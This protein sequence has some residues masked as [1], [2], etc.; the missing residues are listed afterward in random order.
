MSDVALSIIARLRQ[1]GAIL[2]CWDGERVRFSAPAPLPAALLAEAR[3][4]RE[5]I[6]VA[7]TADAMPTGPEAATEAVA[8]WIERAAGEALDGYVATPPPPEWPEA[9][10]ERLQSLSRQITSGYLRAALRRPP[11]WSRV[12]KH[13]PTPGATCSCCG[14]ARWWSRDECGWRCA[15]CHPSS[16]AGANNLTEVRT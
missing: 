2:D 3:Q 4:H 7:L 11:S 12:E 6:A 10:R 5:V 9:E 16:G 15:T 1:A 13:R 14:G 8:A